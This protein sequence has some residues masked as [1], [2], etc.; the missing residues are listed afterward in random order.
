MTVLT[1]QPEPLDM[2]FVAKGHGLIW[3]LTLPRHPGRTLQLIER[4]SQG[5][6][7]QPRQHQAH[8]SQRV[9]AA[10]KDLR[11][12]CFSCLITTQATKAVAVGPVFCVWMRPLCRRS[13]RLCTKINLGYDSPETRGTPKIKY[14]SLKGSRKGFASLNS[15]KYCAKWAA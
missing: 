11:H 3:T 4:N 12:E 1:L 2:V 15:K 5:D 14:N 6:H 7:N 8:A 10:F 13:H 9:G